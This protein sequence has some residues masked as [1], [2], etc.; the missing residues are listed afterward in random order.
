MSVYFVRD[1]SADPESAALELIVRVPTDVLGYEW[2]T[3]EALQEFAAVLSAESA[4]TGMSWHDAKHA[5]VA[6]VLKTQSQPAPP[7]G[8]LIPRRGIGA[9]RGRRINAGLPPS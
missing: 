6:I 2:P 7:S 4:F 9:N 8:P 5:A 1:D 3:R